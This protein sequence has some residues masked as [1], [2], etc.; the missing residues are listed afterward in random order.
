MTKGEWLRENIQWSKE[1]QA[2]YKGKTGNVY[3]RCRME[4]AEATEEFVKEDEFDNL[5]GEWKQEIKDNKER[6]REQVRGSR[7]IYGNEREFVEAMMDKYQLQIDDDDGVW[8]YIE[9]GNTMLT[10]T[11]SYRW[12]HKLKESITIYNRSIPK[13]DDGNL[14]GP[15]LEFEAIKSVQ[16]NLLHERSAK[17][18]ESKAVGMIYDPGS[19]YDLDAHIT[20]LFRAYRIAVNP[21]NIIMWK[22]MMWQIKRKVWMLPIP[23]PM[24]FSIRSRRQKIGK[25]R[26]IK[27]HIAGVFQRLY[28]EGAS[29]SMLQTKK[30]AAAMLRGKVVADFA[31]LALGKGDVGYKDSASDNAIMSLKQ[32]I[33]DQVMSYRPN[34]KDDYVHEKLQTV[35]L[36]STNKHIYDVLTDHTGMRRY[37]EWELIMESDADRPDFA[38]GNRLLPH[39]IEAYKCIDE[40]LEEG[41]ISNS[42]LM[43]DLE[44]VQADYLADNVLIKFCKDEGYKFQNDSD[45]AVRVTVTAVYEKFVTYCVKKGRG[46]WSEESMTA[47]IEEALDVLPN[48]EV[49]PNMKRVSYYYVEGKAKTSPQVAGGKLP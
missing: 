1:G 48:V 15:N 7:E 32:I 2:K 17:Y 12:M 25:T 30:E 19:E 23:L 45:G 6:D 3:Q 20:T 44:R 35:F 26:M 37:F 18:W 14:L 9:L 33:T 21:L 22:E 29:L 43:A 28:L 11:T 49:L 38:S 13:D 46:K 40:S 27:D 5:M 34:Y 42:P 47:G 31:E 8:K 36:A 4:M 24:M 16:E 39:L 41:Y 10:Q